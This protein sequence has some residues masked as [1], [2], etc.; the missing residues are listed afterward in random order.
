M[1]HC[2]GT[3]V[4][5]LGE[6]TCPLLLLYKMGRVVS[7]SDPTA[8]AK[9]V[10]YLFVLS[11]PTLLSGAALG[12]VGEWSWDGDTHLWLRGET[13]W[14][15]DLRKAGSPSI[16]ACTRPAPSLGEWATGQAQR[17]LWDDTV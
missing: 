9:V 4:T 3:Y 17:V 15:L 5:L 11:F 13:T 16:P 2:A 10:T 14:R 12:G 7:E 8:S 6:A 1:T